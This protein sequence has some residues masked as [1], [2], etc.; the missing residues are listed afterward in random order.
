MQRRS[1]R[2]VT[3]FITVLGTFPGLDAFHSM[4]DTVAGESETAVFHHSV[5]NVVVVH[6][7]LRRGRGGL[8]LVDRHL[9]GRH[10]GGTGQDAEW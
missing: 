6:V 9:P 4:V 8:G 5:G 3:S 1:S 7:V 10:D 2:C